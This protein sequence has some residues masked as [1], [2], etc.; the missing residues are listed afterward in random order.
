[1]NDT[2]SRIRLQQRNGSD[3]LS[4][5]TERE[6]GLNRNLSARK[7][8]MIALGGA[9]GT[10]LFLGSAF[11]IS[12][13]GP[14]ALVSYGLSAFL[15]V[16]MM[17]CLA[18]MTLAHPTSGSFGSHAEH[19]LGPLAG[20]LVRY[21]YWAAAVFA[22]GSEVAA[23]ALYMKFWLPHSPGWLW[24]AGFSTVL[25]LANLANVGVFGTIEY[26]FSWLKLTAIGLFILLAGGFLVES[27]LPFTATGPGLTGFEHYLDHYGDHGGFFPKGLGGMGG[28]VLIALFSYLGI[29][30]VAVAAGEAEHPEVAIK[31]AFRT[32]VVRLVLFYLV[33]IA[34][35][36]AIVPWTD[37]IVGV[38]P[39]VLAMQKLHIPGA[40]GIVNFVILIAALSAVNSQLYIATRMMF[41]L[42]RAG[43]AP[44]ALG[45]VHP[46]GVPVNALLVSTLGIAVST[47]LSVFA[48][49]S[50]YLVMVAIAI[51]GALFT[52]LMIFVTH[53]FFR[54]ERA[55]AGRLPLSFQMAGFPALT[56][57]G[58]TGMLAVLFGT[59]LSRPFHLTLIFGLAFLACMTLVYFIRQAVRPART[60]PS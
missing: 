28:A 16:L 38:S 52:W 50:A 10:G 20:F 58:A 6:R 18:E 25:V 2:V 34:L 54:R 56:L 3:A 11:S 27:L 30:M 33:T 53:Y 46:R 57:L 24:S 29:E 40:A 35:L 45:K 13:A 15:T 22:V 47:A 23:I 37:M 59:L 31:R 21:A 48:P 19:Y 51:F 14:A 39:F 12:L 32:A 4:N 26:W 55:R 49:D 60:V 8:S 44:R 5:I 36:L 7:M 9:I 17:G 43:D 42:A 41:S 1:M